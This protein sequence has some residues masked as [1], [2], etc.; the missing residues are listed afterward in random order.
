M[1]NPNCKVRFN[2]FLSLNQKCRY[3]YYKLTEYSIDSLAHACA[4]LKS[5]LPISNFRLLAIFVTDG[6]MVDVGFAGTR[7]TSKSVGLSWRVKSKLDASCRT[8]VNHSE[9]RH[10][11][12]A[13]LA[14]SMAG[15]IARGAS[16]VNAELHQLA[17]VVPAGDAPSSRR[18]P[19]TPTGSLLASISTYAIVQ[20][21][22]KSPQW[23]SQTFDSRLPTV[24]AS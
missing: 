18:L 10:Q 2:T 4:L 8:N 5:K 6:A 11:P 19:C 24:C 23:A 1:R 22:S 16:A 17:C 21:G 7:P 9:H 12:A 20:R 3:L 13:S 15:A 14:N